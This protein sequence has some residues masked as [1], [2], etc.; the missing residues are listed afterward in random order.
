MKWATGAHGARMLGG[1]SKFLSEVEKD[2]AKYLNK[3]AC[4]IMSSG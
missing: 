2:V 1:N 4:M 3:D